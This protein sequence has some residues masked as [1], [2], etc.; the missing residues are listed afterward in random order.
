MTDI[1]IIE[2]VIREFGVVVNDRPGSVYHLKNA[3]NG[4]ITDFVPTTEQL[5]ALKVVYRPLNIRTLFSVVERNTSKIEDL[6]NKQILNY[7]ETY[8][9][10]EPGLF[11]LEVDGG[12][13]FTMNFVKAVTVEELGE[14]VKKIVYSNAPINDT[15][16]FRDIIV[17]YNVGIDVNKIKNNEMKMFFIDEKRDTLDNGDDVVRFV[18]YKATGETMLIKSPEV[19][20]PVIQAINKTFIEKAQANNFDFS[21]LDK[22]SVRDKLKYLN[23]IRFRKADVGFDSFVIRNGKIHTKNVSTKSNPLRLN[24]IEKEVLASLK[25]DLAFLNGQNVLLDEKVHYGLP[26]SRKQVVGKIPF[27]TTVEMGEKISSGIYWKNGWGARDLDLS[28]ID[29]SGNRVGWGGRSAYGNGDI[30]FSG[31]MTYA[32]PEAM[33]FMTS[34]NTEYGLLVNIYS[35]ITGCEAEIVVGTTSKNRWIEDVFLREKVKLASKE[36]V[37][38]FVNKTKYIAFLGRTGNRAVS[39]QLNSLIKKASLSVWTLNE[40]F[41]VLGIKYDTD[42]KEGVD[43]N[44]NLSYNQFSYDKLEEL[45][46]I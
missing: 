14:M 41:D 20:V 12:V 19:L 27:G 42:E 11:N 24:K 44:H 37:I 17:E 1:T 40:L 28:T 39:G 33:E 23:V 15:K 4:F 13:A 9:L 7:I 31:D 30:I 10:R 29:I 36:C 46:G 45:V 18:V 3:N 2:N 32:E 6:I 26:T 38:G 21:V 16:V 22:I 25:K 35:G 34:K 43:Y 8:G 5:A